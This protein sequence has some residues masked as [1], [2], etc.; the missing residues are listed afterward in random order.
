M[1]GRRGRGQLDAEL[2][3]L[4]DKLRHFQRQLLD[5]GRDDPVA[6]AVDL[7]DGCAEALIGR[8]CRGQLFKQRQQ[9]LYTA[10]GRMSFS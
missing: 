8:L 1:D 9:R 7:F 5:A 3:A 10:F 2:A 4:F 6:L